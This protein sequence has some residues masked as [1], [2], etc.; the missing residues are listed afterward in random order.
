VLQKLQPAELAQPSVAL[1][2]GV[3]L[4]ATGKPDQAM[5]WLQ[6]A[7]T[8]GHLLPEEKELL[9]IAMGKGQVPQP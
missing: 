8:K 5:P 6:I 3:L 2:Y 1:Y 7:Q 4:A 9:A